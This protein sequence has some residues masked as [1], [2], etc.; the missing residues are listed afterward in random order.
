MRIARTWLFPILRVSPVS[1]NLL[2][3]SCRTVFNPV[4][5]RNEFS[6]QVR[7]CRVCVLRD[8]EILDVGGR[9]AVAAVRLFHVQYYETHIYSFLF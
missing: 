6:V 5:V 2:L 7:P 1:S 3:Y 8:D 4:G 9:S